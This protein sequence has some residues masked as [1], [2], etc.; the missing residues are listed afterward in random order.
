MMLTAER[1]KARAELQLIIVMVKASAPCSRER[2]RLEDRARLLRHALM[3]DA[4]VKKAGR[5]AS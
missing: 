3:R 1:R 4:Q 5:I 2:T